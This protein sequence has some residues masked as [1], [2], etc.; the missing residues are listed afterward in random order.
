VYSTRVKVLAFEPNR[1]D[2]G[3]VTWYFVAILFEE[4]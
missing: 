3:L 1:R 2:A 4:R